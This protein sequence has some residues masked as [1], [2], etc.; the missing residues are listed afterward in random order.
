MSIFCVS[1]V[2][3]GNALFELRVPY[4]AHRIEVLSDRNLQRGEERGN[5]TRKENKE[6]RVNRKMGAE[7]KRK[8]F[9]NQ[10]VEPFCFIS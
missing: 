2:A 1:E 8:S 4:V 7:K 5:V 9:T 3:L 10:P 6:D